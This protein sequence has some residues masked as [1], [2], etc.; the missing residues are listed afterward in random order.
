MIIETRFVHKI[1][2]A[3]L[4]HLQSIKPDL[5][6]HV[7]PIVDPYGP[8]IVDEGLEAIIVRFGCFLI[9]YLFNSTTIDNI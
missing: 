2:L 1:I 9:Q 5:D 8:S 7:E 4:F 3:T 6:V